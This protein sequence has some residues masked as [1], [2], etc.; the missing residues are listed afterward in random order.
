[1]AIVGGTC[2]SAKRDFL[3][4]VHG[5]NDQY[6][7]ALYTARA[8]LGPWT[9]TYTPDGEVESG[10][11]YQRGGQVLAGYQCGLDG[12]VAVLGWR[13]PVVWPNSTITAFGALIYNATKGNRALVV[14]DFSK[15]IVSTDGPYRLL[16]P[17]ISAE[18]ALIRIF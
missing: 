3:L 4:G 10:N 12:D 8:H 14:V 18:S 15:P 16:M 17:P 13:E 6:R 2:V 11:G 9:P 5:P 1:M 7:I